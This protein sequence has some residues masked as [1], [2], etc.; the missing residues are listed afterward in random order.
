MNWFGLGTSVFDGS[1]LGIDWNGSQWIA[2]GS[3][4]VN[5][6]AKS[7]DIM[8]T[9]WTGLG[10]SVFSMVNCVKW[11]LGSW[12]VGAD[13]SGGS[14]MA[15]SVDGTT[16]TPI[17]T[18]LSTTCYSISW[19][20]REAIAVGTGTSKMVV[21][22]DGINWSAVSTGITGGYGIEWNGRE[23]I[24]AASGTYAV[25]SA[26]DVSGTINVF[27]VSG[28][29]SL[30]TQ[31]YCVGANSGIGSKVFNNRLYL[32]GGNKLVVYGPE[33]YDNGL[34]SDTSISMNMNLPV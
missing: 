13:A 29:S 9:N 14:T 21:S 18:G 16:W 17:T 1:G 25:N 11:M 6:I 7:T 24:V 33:Y 31:G 30:L 20:G 19:N 4:T 15:S 26:I 10:N 34:M 32:N 12:F 3:G 2:V 8:A 5:T 23:W 27:A 22:S 28:S